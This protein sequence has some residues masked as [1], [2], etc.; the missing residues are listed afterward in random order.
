MITRRKS[1]SLEPCQEPVDPEDDGIPEEILMLLLGASEGIIPPH[2]EEA[3]CRGD[4]GFHDME[5]M[6][7]QILDAC[8]R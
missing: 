7:E 6:T 1:N 3:P 5:D 8:D 4:F 2:G